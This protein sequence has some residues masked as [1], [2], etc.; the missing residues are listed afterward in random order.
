MPCVNCDGREVVGAGLFVILALMISIIGCSGAGHTIQSP[1]RDY[2]YSN[3]SSPDLRAAFDQARLSPGMPYFV[4]DQL[5]AEWQNDQPRFVPGI[6]SRQELHEEEGWGRVYQDPWIKTC[7]K[8]FKTDAGTVA[9]WYEYPDFYLTHVKANDTLVVFR[10]DTALASPISCLKNARYL[11]VTNSLD[12][13]SPD[14]FFSA[15]IRHVDNPRYKVSH[16][17]RLE[18]DDPTTFY[19]KPTGFDLY[20]IE[21]IE[22]DGKP[23]DYFLWRASDENQ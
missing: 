9:I 4:V 20:R 16:W 21:W 3:I 22:I 10:E 15:E 7:M 17:Y 13:L 19:L 6:G 18:A 8:E 1:N 2:F 11:S 14:T 5:F 23:V 12:G